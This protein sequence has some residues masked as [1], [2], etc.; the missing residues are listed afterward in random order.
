M[1]SNDRRAQILRELKRHGSFNVTEFAARVGIS[2]MTIR[3]DLESLEGQGA[4]QRVHGG[5]IPVPASQRPDVIGQ[6]RQAGS[7]QVPAVQRVRMPVRTIGMV[8]PSASYY[9]PSVIR[10]AE[11]AARDLGARIVL[12]VSNYSQAEEERQIQRLLANGVDG[13]I[14]TPSRESLSGTRTLELLA[15][16]EI[17]IVIAERPID[18]VLDEVQLESVRSDHSRGAEIAVNHLLD[19]GHTKIGLCVRET[20]PTTTRVRIG[21][22]QA[23]DRAGV[24]RTESMEQFMT[25]E[26]E[27]PGGLHA[28]FEDRVDWVVSSGFTALLVLNDE[29]ALALVDSCQARGLSV[30]GD[31]A[32]VAYDDEVAS[33]GAVPLTAVSPPKHDVGYQALQMCLSRIESAPAKA[34]AMKQVT[35]S[36]RLVVRESSAPLG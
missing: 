33:M 11:E 9:F 28:Y 24:S 19:L 5:A 13:L 1:L 7:M 17:P 22:R 8:M 27:A 16:A 2:G 25:L 14:V 12:A 10:G 35:L 29:D 3:R 4:L 30:P 20:S 18:D 6:G 21:Y 26:Q 23:L 34:P 31:I 32:I 36:P 15:A